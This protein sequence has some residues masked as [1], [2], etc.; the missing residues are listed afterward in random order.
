MKNLIYLFESYYRH[1]KYEIAGAFLPPSADLTEKSSLARAFFHVAEERIARLM[2]EM[3]L[4]VQA[5]MAMIHHKKPISRL[6]YQNRL[7]NEYDQILHRW[8]YT[9]TSFNESDIRAELRTLHLPCSRPHRCH[10]T[11]LVRVPER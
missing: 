2:R 9:L 5:L 3:S 8:R 7:H 10:H 1:K 6:Y 11:N 4:T